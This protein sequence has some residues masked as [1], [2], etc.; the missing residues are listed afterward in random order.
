MLLPSRSVLV[1]DDAIV[2]DKISI[3]PLK[4]DSTINIHWKL[5]S[6]D[7][8]TKGSLTLDIKVDIKTHTERIEV[9]DKSEERV[10]ELPIEDYIT[11]GSDEDE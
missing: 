11:N 3:R 4:E 6:E 5:V 7:F 9:T 1:Q 10:V 2:F 8:K